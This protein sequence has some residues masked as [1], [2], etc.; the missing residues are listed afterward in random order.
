MKNRLLIIYFCIG[1][2]ILIIL[3]TI[4]LLY[5]GSAFVLKNIHIAGNRVLSSNSIIKMSGLDYGTALIK[6]DTN[7][8]EDKLRLNPLITNASVNYVFPDSLNINIIESTPIILVILNEQAYLLDK[9]AIVMEITDKTYENKRFIRVEFLDDINSSYNI[10]DKIEIPSIQRLIDVLKNRTNDYRFLNDIENIN[11]ISNEKFIL[12]FKS[13][14]TDFIFSIDID[15]EK[16]KKAEIIFNNIKYRN[17]LETKS[18]I[19][20]DDFIIGKE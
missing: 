12:K 20:S 1:I 4:L 2:V 3:L 11:I 16:I 9:N 14:N 7:Y 5:T 19:I 8:V 17:N 10:K 18:I 15:E 13:I 6:V